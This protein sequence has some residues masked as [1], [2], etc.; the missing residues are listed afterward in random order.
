MR[1]FALVVLAAAVVVSVRSS[2]Q[3]PPVPRKI[4]FVADVRPILSDRCYEC[5]GPAKQMNGLRLARRH[6]ALRGG[7]IPVI[8]PGSAA[9]SRLYLRLTGTSYGHQMAF[10][11]EP[12]TPG[13]IQ[14]I[15]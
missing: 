6:D 3:A 13:Q 7:P 8:G 15:K 1:K 11:V 5:H 4:D 14:T 9:S 10:E 12:L 2:A